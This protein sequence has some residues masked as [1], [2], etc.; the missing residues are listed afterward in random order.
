LSWIGDLTLTQAIIKSLD[1]VVSCDTA[2]AH[3]AG[4][5]GARGWLALSTAADWRWMLNRSDT[6]WY[7]M[8]RLFRQKQLGRW[9]GV[10]EEMRKLAR[11]V[12]GTRR[13]GRTW[14]KR[15]LY[16]VCLLR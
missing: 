3:L 8:T 4:A 11:L 1:L 2:V 6:P 16:G 9:E 7:P 12:V 10:F 14:R 5:R 13:A 15:R